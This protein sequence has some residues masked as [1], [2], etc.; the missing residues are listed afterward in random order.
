[1]I[2]SSSREA[3][4]F[5]TKQEGGT[6]DGKLISKASTSWSRLKDPRIVRVSRAFGGKDR[7]SKVCTV[8]GLRDRRVRLSVPTAIQLYDLQDRLGLNQPSKVV[9]WLL[10]AAKN[11]IDELPPL[12]M[13]PG[14]FQSMLATHGNGGVPQTEKEG[15]KMMNTSINWDDPVD[16]S[17]SNY[18]SS[19]ATFRDM[20]SKE[21][22]M[23]EGKQGDSSNNFFSRPNYSSLPGML[24]NT[25]AHNSSFLRWDPSNLSLSHVSP[26]AEDLHNFNIVPLP[27]T[28]SQVLVYPPPVTTQSYFPPHVAATGEF[29]PK[30]INFQMLSPSSSQNPLLPSSV[31]VPPLYTISQAMRPFPLSV[32]TPNKLFPSQ[33]NRGSE[34]N[35]D[36]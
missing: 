23:A 26:Q 12:Q 20:K 19:Q 33:N 5:T 16:L 6:S 9:D 8:R 17:R 31:S 34:P 14:N 11:E 7:H 27:S 28:L 13:P 35:K 18:W 30:Q 4:D 36:N 32:T 15:L 24:N 3:A 2:T 1:M 10:N 25:V 22:E 21:G 29:D